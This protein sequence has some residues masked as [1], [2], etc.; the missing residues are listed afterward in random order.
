MPEPGGFPSHR[1]LRRLYEASHRTN[2]RRSWNGGWGASKPLPRTRSASAHWRRS[3][4]DS[5]GH[6]CSHRRG[7]EPFTPCQGCRRAVDPPRVTPSHGFRSMAHVVELLLP[8]LTDPGKR[9][10]SSVPVGPH[11]VRLCGANRHRRIPLRHHPSPFRLRGCP[12]G[13]GRVGMRSH[14]YCHQ[15]REGLSPLSDSCPKAGRSGSGVGLTSRPPLT[16]PQSAAGGSQRPGPAG[17]PAPGR[18]PLRGA[19][20][21]C[22]RGG[23]SVPCPGLRDPG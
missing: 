1:S 18:P 19:P 23:G 10:C 7:A 21:R 13:C 16:S 15:E 3:T 2:R 11:A 5:S 8:G 4:F 22:P 6:R 9:R 20:P 12:S 17:C 14:T